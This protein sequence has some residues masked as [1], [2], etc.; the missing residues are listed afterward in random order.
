MES[1]LIGNNVGSH[2]NACLTV[3]ISIFDSSKCVEKFDGLPNLGD[4][5]SSLYQSDQAPP[6]KI[7]GNKESAGGSRLDPICIPVDI[8]PNVTKT[9][10]IGS[11][12]IRISFPFSKITIS[13]MVVGLLT[14]YN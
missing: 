11:T 6:F 13:E 9:M 10:S 5:G 14:G 12:G 3:N 7:S 1:K 4:S 8:D 2:S